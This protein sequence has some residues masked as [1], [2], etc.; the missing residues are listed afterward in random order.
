M[1]CASLALKGFVARAREVTLIYGWRIISA[2]ARS[3]L[4][5]LYWK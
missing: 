2:S 3:N 5:P 1:L 4:Y